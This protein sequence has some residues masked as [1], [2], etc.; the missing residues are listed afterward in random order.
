MA[1][2]P[3]PLEPERPA[4]GVTHEEIVLVTCRPFE[5]VDLTPRILEIVERAGLVDGLVSVQTRHTTTGIALNENEPL[6]FADVEERLGRFA[7]RRARYRHDD[8]RLRTVNLTDAERPNGHAH[9]RALLLGASECVHVADGGLRL[10]RWQR[11]LFVEL[12]GP[13]R[14]RVSVAAIGVRRC[15]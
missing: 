1:A 12:D 10:G 9:A 4:P 15:G 7:P 13:Q 2:R 14:R 5:F 3:L 8:L 6:L 11:I